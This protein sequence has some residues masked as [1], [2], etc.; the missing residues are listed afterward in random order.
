MAA[1]A[2]GRAVSACAVIDENGK[3]V[4]SYGSNAGPGAS[5]Y[6]PGPGMVT[7]YGINCLAYNFSNDS[8]KILVLEYGHAIALVVNPTDPGN[9]ADVYST[10]VALRVSPR[11]TSNVLFGDGSV[12]GYT[13]QQIDP[14]VAAIRLQKWLPEI[15]QK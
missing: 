11:G 9:V 6:C 1:G 3:T 8:D 7:D 5:G 15:Y 10:L 12:S 14:T 4:F 2:W 13:P